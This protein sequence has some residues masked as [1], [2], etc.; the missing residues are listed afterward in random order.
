M[1]AVA[2]RLLSPI[3]IQLVA[4]LPGSQNQLISAKMTPLILRPSSRLPQVLHARSGMK[5][6]SFDRTAQWTSSSVRRCLL[7]LFGGLVGG[8]AFIVLM[9]DVPAAV[10]GPTPS[11]QTTSEH[12]SFNKHIALIVFAHCAPCHQPGQNAPFDLLSFN[13]VRKRAEQIADVVERRIMPPWMPELGHVEFIGQRG[14]PN[15]QIEAI[16][17]WVASGGEEGASN[18]LPSFTPTAQGWTLGEPDLI[19][20][21]E[22]PFKLPADG[23]DVYRNFVIPMTLTQRR[24]L[25]GIDFYPRTRAIH[26]AFVRFDRTDG[27]RRADQEDPGPGFGG[28]HMPRSVE[29]PM[30]QFLSW[31][32]GKTPFLVAADVVSPIQPG[33]DLVVQIHIEP[34]GREVDIAPEI[35]L[36]FT[37]Q[38]P[39]RS[40][41][42]IPLGSMEIDIPAGAKSH[43]VRDEFT[44][45]V[46]VELRAILPHAHYLARAATATALLPGGKTQ[47]LL[48]I[49]QWNFRWQGDYRYSHP[50]RL[51]KGTRIQFELEYDNSS[52]NPANPN[53]PPSR[54]GYGSDS[55]DEMCELWLQVVLDSKHDEEILVASLQPRIIKD[56]ISFNR[57][58]L[59]KNPDDFRAH[60]ELGRALHMNRDP[61]GAHEHFFEAIRLKPDFDEPHYYQGLLFRAQNKV[62][63]AEQSFRRAIQLNPNHAKAHGNLGFVLATK[64]RMKE[65]EPYLAKAVELDPTDTVARELL[66]NVR[67]LNKTG[68]K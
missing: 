38:P 14:L 35:G 58:L 12:L 39:T 20:R 49:N 47:P 31:Q 57:Y 21:L 10:P 5:F 34:I 2:G 33:S 67:S 9:P 8:L 51:P 32:P 37:D 29:N 24:F 64:Q 48:R 52:E 28:I 61:K 60:S 7:F 23:R 44:L 19:I 55:K 43:I 63:E 13:D 17:K 11:V 30:G 54:V 15:E 27:S 36:Y 16:R 25:R 42:K 56:M 65:A 45:P 53:Q 59:R 40:S 46:D 3:I 66:I 68:A 41:F 26:H 6:H 1:S 4:G 22:A 50:P 18:P 62:A